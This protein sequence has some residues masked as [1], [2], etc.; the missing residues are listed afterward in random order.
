MS[1]SSDSAYGH[2]FHGMMKAM[3]WSSGLE[4]CEKF[5][6]EALHNCPYP[7]RGERDWKKFK[8]SSLFSFL[9]S[10]SMEFST[11]VDF[12]FGSKKEFE[13]NKKGSGPLYFPVANKYFVACR[14][15][16]IRESLCY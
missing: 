1:G 13:K 10:E 7:V 9:E 2:W 15:E 3:P 16:N 4:Q 6:T 11:E 14:L 5:F 8:N 12:A